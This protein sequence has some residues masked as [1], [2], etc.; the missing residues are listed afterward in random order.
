MFH[1]L[2]LKLA[3]PQLTHWFVGR[4]SGQISNNF[5]FPF[6]FV[7]CVTFFQDIYFN[8]AVTISYTV[9]YVLVPLSCLLIYIYT[10]IYQRNTFS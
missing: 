8:S 2:L 9:K 6:V 4:I 5:F 7:V 1:V 10:Y 3:H